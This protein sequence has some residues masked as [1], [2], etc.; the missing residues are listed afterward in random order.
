MEYVCRKGRLCERVC[1]YS[2]DPLNMAAV[3]SSPF[4]TEQALCIML[5][6]SKHMYFGYVGALKHS[7]VEFIGDEDKKKH[8]R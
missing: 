1:P 8:K 4:R 7:S 3:V 6:A 2:T 5:F